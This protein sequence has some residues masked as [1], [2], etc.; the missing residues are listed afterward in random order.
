MQTRTALVSSVAAGLALI[1][2]IISYLQLFNAQEVACPEIA[3]ARIGL[4]AAYDQGVAASVEV[5]RDQKI[6]IDENLD[7]CLNAK[8][9]NPCDELQRE[10]DQSVDDF[11]DIEESTFGSFNS[12]LEARDAAYK[13]YKSSKEALDQ[14]K[15]DN[16]QPELDIPYEKTDAKKCFDEYDAAV[17]GIRN[18]FETNTQAMQ[19]AL[20][21]DMA[22]L[23]A[24]EKACNPP[25]GDESFTNPPGDDDGDQGDE[26]NDGP[27]VALANCRPIDANLDAELIRLK[28]RVGQIPGEISEVQSSID[29]A[30][31]RVNKLKGELAEVDTYIPPESTKTQFEGA[32]NALRGERKMNIETQIEFY[33]NLS[34][35]KKSEKE[36]LQSELKEVNAKIQER[37]NQIKKDNEAR[38]RAFPTR[39]HI[40]GPDKC[41]YFHCHGTL[42]GKQDPAPNE[43]GHGATTQGDAGCKE[44]FNKYL[45]AAGI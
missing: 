28:E 16:P 21:K 43:C 15:K 23:N 18:T 13:N 11:N 37:L 42:C 34:N 5:Y 9:K 1:V 38:Q 8:P 22:D 6:M 4:Q 36:N 3:Q 26:S 32:L 10:R 20:A 31:R 7:Y 29:N 45:E 25:T 2:G 33:E 41:E 17:Q 27:D 12:Y 44:F 24:R 14:C 30:D 40:S 19:T 39:I 35:R